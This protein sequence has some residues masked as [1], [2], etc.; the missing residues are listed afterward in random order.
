[1]AIEE[2]RQRKV[3]CDRCRIGEVQPLEAKVLPMGWASV[4]LAVT[5]AAIE[6]PQEFHLCPK[7]VDE[8]K[9]ALRPLI[10]VRRAPVETILGGAPEN[11]LAPNLRAGAY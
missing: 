4:S 6:S 5:Q 11:I 10:K 1:M 7:H 8:V 3:T 2:I 9:E